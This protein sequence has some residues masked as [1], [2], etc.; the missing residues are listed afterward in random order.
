M[1]LEGEKTPDQ[2]AKHES[3]LEQVMDIKSDILAMNHE[4]L[5]DAE[6]NLDATSQASIERYIDA[7]RETA[8]AESSLGTPENTQSSVELIDRAVE[9]ERVMNEG[10]TSGA[11][12]ADLNSPPE[13]GGIDRIYSYPVDNAPSKP[14][15]I[16]RPDKDVAGAQVTNEDLSSPNPRTE[17]K[18]ESQRPQPDAVV[19]DTHTDTAPVIDGVV[20]DAQAEIE[21]LQALQERLEREREELEGHTA[22][23]EGEREE[24]SE[25][26]S[27]VANAEGGSEYSLG[28]GGQLTTSFRMAGNDD[29]SATA[30]RELSNPAPAVTAASGP[31]GMG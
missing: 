23:L 3:S 14:M 16:A 22:E 27:F 21:R 17:P 29:S 31:S 24:L 5:E 19:P 7:L 6:V 18:P 25:D 1:Q 13:P 28:K 30:T 15:G 9:M 10:I 11:V 4:R 20:A 8:A 2:I 26:V 12:T